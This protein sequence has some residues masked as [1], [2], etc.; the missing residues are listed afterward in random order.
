MI[1]NVWLKLILQFSMIVGD[2][3]IDDTGAVQ[4]KR[5]KLLEGVLQT[6]RLVRH[7]GGRRRTILEVRSRWVDHAKMHPQKM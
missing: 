2:D 5:R 3:E 7:T 4:E 6:V 1:L